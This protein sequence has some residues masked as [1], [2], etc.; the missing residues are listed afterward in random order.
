MQIFVFRD[1][2]ETS[3]GRKINLYTFTHNDF[4]RPIQ[5]QVQHFIKQT[6]SM[7]TKLCKYIINKGTDPLF[8]VHGMNV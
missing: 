6:S 1:L 5:L 8:R 4:H 2:G 7:A 3:G